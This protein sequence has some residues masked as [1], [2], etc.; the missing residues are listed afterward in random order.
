VKLRSG[1]R[2]ARARHG[3]EGES[4]EE[5]MACIRVVQTADSGRPTQAT[6]SYKIPRPPLLASSPY[7]PYQ[8][9]IPSLHVHPFRID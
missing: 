8:L 1:M 7:N 2:C 3:R 5:M 4:R 9:S 6:S